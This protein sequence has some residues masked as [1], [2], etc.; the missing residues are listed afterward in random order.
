MSKLL[1]GEQLR[2]M[3]LHDAASASLE[4][5]QSGSLS[6]RQYNQ[7]HTV[8]ESEARRLGRDA[9][10][11]TVWSA[12][13]GLLDTP[14]DDQSDIDG[15]NDEVI[16][17]ILKRKNDKI[18]GY[19]G[20]LQD[21]LPG[22]YANYATRVD[23]AVVAGL[24]PEVMQR[25]LPSVIE[26]TEWLVSDGMGDILG[27]ASS[28]DRHAVLNS[29]L[30]TIKDDYRTKKECIEQ[31][32]TH[33]LTHRLAGT[34]AV[35]HN[36]EIIRYRTGL[37]V[38]TSHWLDE[39]TTELI[40]DTLTGRDRRDISMLSGN[41][42]GTYIAE[43]AAYGQL[44]KL[45]SPDAMIAYYFAEADDGESKRELHRVFR[46]ELGVAFSQFMKATASGEAR[47]DYIRQLVSTKIDTGMGRL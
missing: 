11:D 5:D 15:F 16:Y 39:V 21:M 13:Y 20:E 7:L 44:L 8:N 18:L 43:R 3:T 36:D 40:T 4:M 37:P 33:E 28:T 45:I 46:D 26:Q 14:L 9:L 34:W 1:F 2:A 23:E 38:V 25:R 30:F 32:F 41:P 22:L 24:L 10:I 27:M 31:I 47:R 35:E 6:F 29:E 17:D 19:V 42:N 12:D